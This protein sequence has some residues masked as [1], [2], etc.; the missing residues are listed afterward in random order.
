MRDILAGKRKMIKSAEVKVI[1]VPHFDGL[2]IDHM[3]EYAALYPTAM[4]AFPIVKRERDKIQRS[5]VANVIYT[6]VGEP[7]KQ[8]VDKRV[9][10]RHAKMVQQ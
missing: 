10:D 8:W 5:Y 4:E 9:N 3:Y 1:T 2:S 6:I 7:F